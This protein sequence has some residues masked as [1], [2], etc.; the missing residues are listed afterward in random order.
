[1]P[2]IIECV[3]NF[4]EGIDLT[5]IEDIVSAVRTAKVL[6]VHSDPDHNRSVV[7]MIGEPGGVGQAAF[8]LTERA[9]Q[10]LDIREHAASILS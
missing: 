10:L 6:D 1:M 5:I 8:D 2:K 9:M 3:P 4:S 7:T